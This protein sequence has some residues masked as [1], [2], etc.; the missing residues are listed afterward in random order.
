LSALSKIKKD[1]V[2]EPEI[3]FILEM[4]SEYLTDQ[5]GF[6]KPQDHCDSDSIKGIARECVVKVTPQ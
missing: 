5:Y 6:E 3:S 1:F 2:T 4:I